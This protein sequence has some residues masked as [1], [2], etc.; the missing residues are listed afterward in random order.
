MSNTAEV[1]IIGGGVHGASLA[2]HLALRGVRA[3]VLERQ[4]VGAGAT[5][6]SSGLVRMHYDTAVEAR[7]AWESFAYF[8]SWGERVGGACGFTRTG[9]LQIVGAQQAEA[10]R[11]NVAMQQRVGIPTTVI[12]AAEIRQLAPAFAV[13]DSELAAYE[14]ESGY[15]MPS[16]TANALMSAARDRGAALVQGCVVTGI[17]V[18]GGRVTGVETTLGCYAAPV[19]VNAA[20]AWAGR[21]NALAGL[22]LPYDTWRHETMFVARPPALATGHPAVIDFPNDMYFRP[23]GG[24]TLVGLEDGNP[25]GESPD[26]DTDQAR[27]G[28]VERA[29]ERICRRVPAMQ[30]GGLQSAHGGYDGITPDQHAMLGAAG[31]EGFFLDCGH[32]GAGFKTA[33]AVGRCMAELIL[34]GAATTVDISPLTPARFAAGRP[35]QGSYAN[36]W[37]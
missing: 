4:F 24:L 31:P 2:F 9:F 16:D 35:V 19:V 20:G 8:R 29:I 32:S 7:L 1:I 33:P 3:T 15:A 26:S 21:I 30:D 37:K 36:L 14:P 22:N 13:D 28:F 34:D 18:V 25:L 11:A 10:L 12:T 17:T 6:R 5:G 23:E 27:A